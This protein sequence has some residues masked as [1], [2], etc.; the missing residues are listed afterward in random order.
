MEDTSN[1]WM[2]SEKANDFLIGTY[3][4]PAKYSTEF[5]SLL[6][7][8]LADTKHHAGIGIKTVD[9]QRKRPKP[10]QAPDAAQWRLA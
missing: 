10:Q 3:Q 1:C 4:T 7:T 9:A 6:L 8:L 5:N 2:E